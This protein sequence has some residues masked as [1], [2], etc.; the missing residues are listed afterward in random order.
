MTDLYE[1]TLSNIEEVKSSSLRFYASRYR[2]ILDVGFKSEG[3]WAI[4]EFKTRSP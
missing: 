3:R 1:G 2:V 4:E